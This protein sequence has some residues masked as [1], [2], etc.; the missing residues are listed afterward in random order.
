MF[1]R[2]NLKYACFGIEEKNGLV[3]KTAPIGR[4]MIGKEISVI[5]NW[6]VSKKGKIEKV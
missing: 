4:W 3:V 1:Y 2:I 6:V 5:K